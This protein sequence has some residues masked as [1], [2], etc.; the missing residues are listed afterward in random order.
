MSER[1]VRITV[2]AAVAVALL[3]GC[4]MPTTQVPGSGGSGG[5]LTIQVGNHINSQTLLPPISMTPV[6]YT[7]SVW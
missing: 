6:S 3:L 1:L 4:P 5:S 2:L 7:V